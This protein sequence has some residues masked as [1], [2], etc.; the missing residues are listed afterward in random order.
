MAAVPASRR[1]RSVF[2]D[3]SAYLA[4]IDHRD[5]HHADAIAI[6][7]RLAAER[8]RLYTASTIVIEAHALILSTMGRDAAT[9]FLRQMERSTIVVVRARATD[10]ARGRAI[11]YT[12][13]DKEWSYTDAISFA[14]M[15]RL[16]IARAFTFDR[17]FAQYGWTV[18]RPD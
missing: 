10:E 1:D 5:E 13:A 12:Y 8:A 6:L 11:L 16:G 14:V 15:E 4:L 17:D 3:S 2:T 9:R 7:R 18:L